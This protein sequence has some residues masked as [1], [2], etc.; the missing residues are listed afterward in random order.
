MAASLANLTAGTGLMQPR[1]PSGRDVQET[2][3]GFQ[4][5]YL[6]RIAAE[7][8][9]NLADQVLVPARHNSLLML[10]LRPRASGGR[11]RIENLHLRVKRLEVQIGRI[12]VRLNFRALLECLRLCMLGELVYCPALKAHARAM[13]ST[14]ICVYL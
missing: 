9:P 6:L 5:R 2:V 7:F 1:R 4:V 11:Y 14:I 10:D 3:P 13:S 8:F 12:S